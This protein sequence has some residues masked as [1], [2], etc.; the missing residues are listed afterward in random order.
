M[1]VL[2]V[3][4]DACVEALSIPRFDALFTGGLD[5]RHEQEM[6]AVVQAAATYIARDYDWPALKKLETITGTGAADDFALPADYG[7]ML[8]KSQLWSSSLDAPLRHVTSDDEWLGLLTLGEFS[9]YGSWILYANRIHIRPTL[10]SGVTVKYFYITE[11][12]VDLQGAGSYSLTFANDTDTFRLDETLLKLAIIWQY[13]ASKGL[14]YAE[15][16]ATYE[17]EK[18][19][20]VTRAKGSRILRIGNTRLPAEVELAYPFSVGT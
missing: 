13:K 9:T 1:T 5:R 4:N 8:V 14:Q 19:R 11:R 2:S 18:E 3:V 12:V 15:D 16:L 10:A 17:R 6:K 20:L 7:R